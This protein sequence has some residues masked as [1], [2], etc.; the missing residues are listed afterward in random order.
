MAYT[1]KAGEG[2]YRKF[3]VKLQRRW[4]TKF[5]DLLQ[6]TFIS[7]STES[8]KPV[9]NW[10]SKLSSTDVKKITRLVKGNLFSST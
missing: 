6:N 3:S 9:K 5:V 4:T 2:V 10:R 8:W 1:V 7:D